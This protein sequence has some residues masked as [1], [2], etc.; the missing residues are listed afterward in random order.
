VTPGWHRGVSKAWGAWRGAVIGAAW[1]GILSSPAA[2]GQ[3]SSYGIGGSSVAPPPVVTDRVDVFSPTTQNDTLLAIG[4]WLIN[5]TSL[6]GV[7][8]DSNPGQT[9]IAKPGFGLRSRSSVIGEAQNGIYD[10]T[11]YGTIDSTLY[12]NQNI[13]NANQFFIDAGVTEI[14]RTLPDLIVS[15]QAN[16]TRQQNLFSN[17]TLNSGLININPTGTGVLPTSNALTYNQLSDIMSIQKNFSDSFIILGGSLVDLTYN[18]TPGVAAT[19]PNGV[20]YTGRARA[21]IW[22]FPDVYTYLEETL[23]TQDYAAAFL[24]SSGNRTV[25]G[26]GSDQFR[27]LRGEVYGGYQSERYRSAA[28]ETVAS[29]VFGGRVSYF[30]LPE[31]TLTTALDKTIGTS[32]LATPTT[33]AATSTGTA[34]VE[35]SFL[36]QAVYAF[37]PE[38]QATARGGYTEANFVDTTHREHALT[39]GATIT[40]SI[41]ENIGL[42]LD[43][44]H[45]ELRSNVVGQSFTRDTATLGLTYRY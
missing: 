33:A 42:A 15:E 12:P 37:A 41:W 17:L 6:A 28:I 22:I 36:A 5:P 4:D 3:V 10:T 1:S 32:L 16:Y 11:V 24:S 21:G 44:Q 43:L 14:Y 26:V 40:Y 29:P 39:L 13:V 9:S 19:A 23:D 45:I 2:W 7:V 25:V 31:L 18:Q 20:I 30:P 27:L 8:A 34:T 38:W 35:T